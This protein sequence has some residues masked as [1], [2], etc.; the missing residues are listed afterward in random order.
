MIFRFG[1]MLL[2]EAMFSIVPIVMII[3]VVSR[4]R[5]VFHHSRINSK[6]PQLTVDDRVLA[7]RTYGTYSEDGGVNGGATRY[8]VTFEFLSGDRLEMEVEGYD[9]GIM[10]EGDIGKLCFKGN[11]FIS[12]AR[13]NMLEVELFGRGQQ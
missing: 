6:A 12:F 7:K 11:R 13:E 2:F 1:S 4:L 8:Y 5:G 10:L 3:I 9:Y